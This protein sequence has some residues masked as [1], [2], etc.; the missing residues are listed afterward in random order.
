MQLD[1]GVLGQTLHEVVKKRNF[2]AIRRDGF[3]GSKDYMI[4]G[5]EVQHFFDAG[6]SQFIDRDPQTVLGLGTEYNYAFGTGRIPIR[7]GFNFVPAGGTAFGRRNTFT[8]GLGYRPNNSTW[9]IDLNW[10]RPQ[11]GGS[12]FSVGLSY[13][14]GN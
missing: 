10:A 7:L 4:L 6:D 13:Q 5:L 1:D 12:D 3:R 14:F 8:F 11:G 2:V 9:G